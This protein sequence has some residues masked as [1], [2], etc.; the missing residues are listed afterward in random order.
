[1]FKFFKDSHSR[2]GDLFININIYIYIC[3]NKAASLP[4]HLE[5]KNL[6]KS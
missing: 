4:L 5:I 3:S 6:K 2:L 1:M